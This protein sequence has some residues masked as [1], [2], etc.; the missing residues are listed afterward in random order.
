M[1]YEKKSKEEIEQIVRDCMVE[2]GIETED[3][4]SFDGYILENSFGK[5][6]TK[7]CN[8]Y[9]ITI[10]DSFGGE[11]QGDEMWAVYAIKKENL[12]EI[13][14]RVSG[15]YDSWNGTEWNGE[16]EVV[17]PKNVTVVQWEYA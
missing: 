2:N 7:P 10:E 12:K 15:Y 6:N 3:T 16:L 5:R 13:Y 17:E 8:G 4:Y 9:T 14:V 11:G 1:V